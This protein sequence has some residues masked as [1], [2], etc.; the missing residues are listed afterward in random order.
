MPDITGTS[1]HAFQ[2]R[3]PVQDALITNSA[4]PSLARE[5]QTF[6][7]FQVVLLGANNAQ[8]ATT[9]SVGFLRYRRLYLPIA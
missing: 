1:V 4:Y 7:G 9:V 2:T 6:S 8:R 5:V 3:L